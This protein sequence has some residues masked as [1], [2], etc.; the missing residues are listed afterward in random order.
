MA[1]ELVSVLIGFGR[2]LRTEGV[3]VGAGDL[4]T[5]A[6]TMA[7]LDPTDLVDLYWGGRTSLVKRRDDLP[8]YDEVFRAYFL[9]ER[10]P[11]QELLTPRPNTPAPGA[12]V[13]DVPATE[14]PDPASTAEEEETVLGL[15]ASD[16]TALRT[17]SFVAC[18]PDEL[19]ALRRIMQQFRLTPPRRRTRRTRPTRRGRRPDMRRTVRRTLRMHG[20]PVTLRWQR[21]QVKMRPLVLILDVSGSMAD[22]SRAM[23]QF[24]H[25]ARRA[26]RRVEV[27]CFGT[28]L[29]RITVPLQKRSPD[30]ALAEA[31]RTVVD[32]EGGTRIGDCLD[33]FAR[34]WGRRGLARG[35]VVVICSDGLDRGSPQTLERAMERLSRLAHTIVWMNPHVSG[36]AGRSR[37]LEHAPRT[38]GMMVAEPHIDVL[39]SGR[40]LESLA[41]LARLLPVL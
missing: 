37:G 18:T 12:P 32:W 11:V 23:L 35:G 7:T 10:N 15:M 36:G 34:T 28:R 9:G 33:E 19:A 29:S 6:A 8:T 17:K 1:D 4:T 31:A 27:F 38:L 14:P 5:F 25:T 21:R 3:T 40:D 20:E 39:L 22:Y 26:A 16:I 41:E 2:A 13:L 24:A 30:A